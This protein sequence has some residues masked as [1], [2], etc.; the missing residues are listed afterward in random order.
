MLFHDWSEHTFENPADTVDCVVDDTE[1]ENSHAVLLGHLLSTWIGAYIEANHEARFGRGCRK[2]HIVLRDSTNGVV[3]NF[4][5]NLFVA[6][7]RERLFEGL[8]GA[9][10]ITFDDDFE[11][12][13]FAFANHR[14]KIVK[15]GCRGLLRPRC[16]FFLLTPFDDELCDSTSILLVSHDEE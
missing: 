15:A 8:N 1:R 4:D 11:L 16:H 13:E 10:H 7:L 12:F 2:V 5:R 6:D 14:R 3:N 9:L